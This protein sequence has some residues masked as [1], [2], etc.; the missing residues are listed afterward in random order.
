TYNSHVINYL[1]NGSSKNK[2]VKEH[3]IMK[4]KPTTHVNLPDDLKYTFYQYK[5]RDDMDGD[6]MG[7]YY[8]S[9]NGFF[10][11]IFSKVFK[12]KKSE[13]DGEEDQ[14]EEK[15]KKEKKKKK[16][17]SFPWTRKK[18]NGENK[19]EHDEYDD[20]SDEEE[21]SNSDRKGSGSRKRSEDDEDD[22]TS[23]NHTGSR[24]HGRGS[25]GGDND[26]DDEDGDES[27][28]N[29]SIIGSKGKKSNGKN[30]SRNRKKKDRFKK[31]K[32]KMKDLFVRVKKNVIPEK[33]KLHIEA[34]FN[35]IIVKTCKDSLKWDGKMFKK[36]SL[37]EMTLKIPVKMK[38][39][40]DKPLDFFRSG[41]EVILTCR[42]C[43]Q[44]LFNSC[45]QVY[46]TKRMTMKD[47]KN[48]GTNAS[49]HLHSD[50]HSAA[51][52]AAHSTLGGVTSNVVAASAGLYAMGIPDFAPLPTYDY[53][54]QLF[55][56]NINTST[57]YY[58][59][60]INIYAKFSVLFMIALMILLI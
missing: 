22:G 50:V 49:A 55:P 53:K 39:I 8:K 56:G 24:G 38:Y 33:Q 6:S 31:I 9:R 34:F 46:C 21:N 14:E 16:K 10:K 60:D 35:S 7:N 48:D 18:K 44:I 23:S 4:E 29:G 2:D 32:T 45:V 37:V 26:E 3:T 1:I 58:N 54:T 30:N 19:S 13:E 25:S 52:G 40:A 5:M 41:Y 59:S 17:W 47:T 15:E 36:Q 57:D 51:N 20:E 28:S 11:S 12:R 27:M 42:N 43:T